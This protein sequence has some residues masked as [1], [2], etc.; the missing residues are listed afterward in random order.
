MPDVVKS[1]LDNTVA[2][3][4]SIAAL[5][6][7]ENADLPTGIRRSC[8]LLR[9]LSRRRKK[10]MFVGNGGSAGIA[11]HMAVDF[12]KNGGI[13]AL[14]FNDSSLLTCVSNDCGY[15]QVF[16]RPIGMFAEAGDL[17]IAISSSGRSPNILKAVKA[18]K[19]KKCRVITL[20]G[21]KADNPLRL[22][23]DINFYVPS[24]EYGPVEVLH[25]FLCH[26][27]LDI[28]LTERKTS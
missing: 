2:L 15:E 6:D 9:E 5:V 17:L 14:A 16:A 27:I 24:S 10:V 11:G 28:Y 12:W 22:M 1:Y 25:Q 18:A 4:R 7:G 23:G 8:R 13:K 20:S 19:S 21:F 3:L 26:Y